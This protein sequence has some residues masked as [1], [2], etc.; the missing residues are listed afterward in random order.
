MYKTSSHIRMSLNYDPQKT[1]IMHYG[2]C[3]VNINY[4]F[5]ALKGSD[6]TRLNAQADPCLSQYSKSLCYLR[7]WVAG[8]PSIIFVT[9]Y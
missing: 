1:F 3:S 8:I 2:G 4:P 5:E 7:Q 6:H 9:V